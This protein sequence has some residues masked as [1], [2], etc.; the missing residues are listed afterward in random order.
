[1]QDPARQGAPAV[2][3]DF[4]GLTLTKIVY[5][6]TQPCFSHA[7]KLPQSKQFSKTPENSCGVRL[8]LLIPWIRYISCSLASS[9]ASF[10]FE[11]A[12]RLGGASRE[13]R[14]QQQQQSGSWREPSRVSRVVDEG[15][16]VHF[17]VSLDLTD[18]PS[19]DRPTR[20]GRPTASA[21]FLLIFDH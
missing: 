13:P 21:R 19:T 12:S 14:R 2:R 5:C 9:S 11:A 16:Q 3:A 6:S 7:E 8:L 1:M 10:S 15:A 18:R 4:S 20:P 17:R